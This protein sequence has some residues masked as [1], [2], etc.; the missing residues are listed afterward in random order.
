ME[1]LRDTSRRVPADEAGPPDRRTATATRPEPK[2]AGHRIT[3]TSADVPGDPARLAKRF[4]RSIT[5]GVMRN[6]QK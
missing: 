1:K 6:R 5:V 3:P 2:Y 4:S